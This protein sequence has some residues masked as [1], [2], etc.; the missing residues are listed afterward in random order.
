VLVLAACGGGRPSAERVV[1]A[2]QPG[3]VVSMAELHQQGCVPA[4]WKLTPPPGD[5]AA[6]EGGRR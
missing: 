1:P 5:P 6:G 3:P 2:S 4:R